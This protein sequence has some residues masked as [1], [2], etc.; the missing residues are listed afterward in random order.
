MKIGL[1]FKALKVMSYNLGTFSLLIS[2][3][4]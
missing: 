4:H 2:L 3:S 1:L